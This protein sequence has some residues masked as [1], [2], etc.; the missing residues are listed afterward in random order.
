MTE[1]RVLRT[2]FTGNKVTGLKNLGILACNIKCKWGK[3][4]KKQNRVSKENKNYFV[5]SFGRLLNERGRE[6]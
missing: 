3:Q 1:E 2:I 6:T 5:G 4:L